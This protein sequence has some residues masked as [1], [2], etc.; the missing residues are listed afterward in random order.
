M[1]KQILSTACLALLTVSIV[2][3]GCKKDDTTSPVVTITGGN[4]TIS[5]QG[6]YTELGATAT[7]DTDDALTA[8]ASGTVNTNQA[9]TYIITYS[10]TDAAGNTGTATRTVIVRNDAYALAGNYAVVDDCSGVIFNYTQTITVSSTVN[11]RIEFNRFADYANNTSIYA[12][13]TGSTINLPSQTAVSI[14]TGS[15]AACEIA[16][17]TFVSQSGSISG[18]NFTITY[19]DQLVGPGSCSGAAASCTA[20]FTKQ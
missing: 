16:N 12:M 2:F 10:A 14:G 9:G 20:V 11:N 8:S 15:A 13:V 19:T 3:T 5:L 4:Q 6:T 18:S 17:H 1:K 7:D